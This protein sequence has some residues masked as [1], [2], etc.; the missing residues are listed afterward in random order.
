MN[1]VK[2]K[3]QNG[4]DEHQKDFKL[5]YKGKYSDIS[6][7]VVRYSYKSSGGAERGSESPP[8]TKY[9]QTSSEGS[10]GDIQSKKEIIKV[11]V[12]WNNKEEIVP[13]KIT[14]DK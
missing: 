13:M 7:S 9:I 10:G 8:G 2:I 11:T 6:K 1:S 5:E 4:Y 3:I 14:N 12:K